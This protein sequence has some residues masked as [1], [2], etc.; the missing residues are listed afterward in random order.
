MKLGRWAGALDDAGAALRINPDA[1]KAKYIVGKVCI[2]TGQLDRARAYLTDAWTSIQLSASPDS[3]ANASW[4]AP[5]KAAL[6]ALRRREFE[7]AQGDGSVEELRA[8]LVRLLEEEERH[9]MDAV[10]VPCQ[11]RRGTSAKKKKE[12]MMESIVNVSEAHA[13]R[14]ELVNQVF[15]HNAS[16][17]SKRDVPEAFL[18]GI[19]YCLMTDPVITPSGHS[20][21]RAS[22]TRHLKE[23]GPFNPM[24]RAPLSAA[25]LVPNIALREAIEQFIEEN[26]WAY[27]DT[28]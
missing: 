12:K 27:E 4:G 24:T 28:E 13:K 22:I 17:E 18:C 20:Y 7:R 5:V 26:P 23:G 6:F 10:H 25:Q 19:S 8:R 3:Q 14:V 2:E 11:S 21:D 9:E 15:R 16:G 1:V